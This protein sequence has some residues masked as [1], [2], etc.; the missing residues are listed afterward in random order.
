MG[1]KAL[2]MQESREVAMLDRQWRNRM[3]RA[4]RL[5]ARIFDI[6]DESLSG[7]KPVFNNENSDKLFIKRL[8][9]RRLAGSD[10]SNEGDDESDGD[11]GEKSDPNKEDD[12]DEDADDGDEDTPDVKK[13]IENLNE[14]CTYHWWQGDLLKQKECW[15]KDNKDEK[16]YIKNLLETLKCM[17]EEATKKDSDGDNTITVFKKK[18]KCL[19]KGDQAKRNK[20]DEEDDKKTKKKAKKDKKEAKKDKKKKKADKKKKKKEKKEEKKGLLD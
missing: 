18:S 17:D 19:E 11:D 7:N 9:A 8:P 20:E 5:T 4:R 16:K 1:Q 3:R 14:I 12:D 6:D 2:N 13:R 10:D 15:V